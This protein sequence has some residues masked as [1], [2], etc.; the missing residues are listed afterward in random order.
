MTGILE[1]YFHLKEHGT[2]IKTECRAGIVTF[3]TKV[4]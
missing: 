4:N 2:D 3:I 1:N